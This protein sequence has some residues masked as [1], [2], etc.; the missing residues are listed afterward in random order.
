M[1]K[2]R[3]D[4]GGT[5]MKKWIF[6]LAILFALAGCGPAPAP[7]TEPA[8]VIDATASPIQIPVT[9]PVE[10]TVLQTFITQATED[11]ANRLGVDVDKI[12]LLEARSVNWRD[13]SLGCPQPDMMYAQ[14]ITP[15]YLLLLDVDGAIYEYHADKRSTVLYCE[16]PESPAPDSLGDS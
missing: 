13:S 1:K 7:E 10:D 4:S 2:R 5:K 16:T 15:G 6:L 11:L 8:P 3:Q 12:T 9:P 14:V